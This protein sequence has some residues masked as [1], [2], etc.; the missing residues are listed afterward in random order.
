[1]KKVK[2]DEEGL[3]TAPAPD[4][5]MKTVQETIE[6]MHQAARNHLLKLEN[7][8]NEQS[9]IIYTMRDRLLD[10]ETEEMFPILLEY[11]EKYIRQLVSAYFP[12]E[13]PE[14]G[15]ER[16]LEQFIKELSLIFT[17]LDWQEE[18]LAEARPSNC[19]GKSAC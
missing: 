5:Y 12:E 3:V 4:K 8:L 17:S 1:M 6:Y 7:P 16:N 10:L 14:E 18:D 11:I 19:R 13:V 2:T 15:Q 9:K